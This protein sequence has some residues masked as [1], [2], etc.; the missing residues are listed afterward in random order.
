MKN[1]PLHKVISGHSVKFSDL[2]SL[3]PVWVNERDALGFTLLFWA[4]FM[5]HHS[6]IGSFQAAGA[7]IVVNNFFYSYQICRLPGFL[8]QEQEQERSRPDVKQE[9]SLP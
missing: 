4:S 6:A 2:I 9:K 7:H 8:L 1:N 5:R 3:D